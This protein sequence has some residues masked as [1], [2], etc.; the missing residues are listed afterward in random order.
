MFGIMNIFLSIST[1][2]VGT[3]PIAIFFAGAYLMMRNWL[4]NGADAFSNRI[5]S[6]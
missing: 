3:F 1:L 2:R 4:L 5:F 6:S